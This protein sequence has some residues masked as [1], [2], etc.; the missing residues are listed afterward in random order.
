[1]LTERVIDQEISR[2]EA[3]TSHEIGPA[4]KS[5]H[6][7]IEDGTVDFDFTTIRAN[8]KAARE[9]LERGVRIL[10]RDEDVQHHRTLMKAFDRYHTV[11]KELLAFEM[12]LRGEP[13]PHHIPSDDL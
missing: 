5:M 12:I 2:F 8:L 3:H 1:M 13:V 7:F 9:R 10:M 4:I 6:K 11:R